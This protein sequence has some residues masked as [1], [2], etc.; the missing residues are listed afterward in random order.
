MPDFQIIQSISDELRRQI[1]T[2]LDTVPGASFGLAGDIDRISLQPPD[3]PMGTDIVASLYLYHIDIDGHLRN[4]PAIPDR[5]AGDLWHQPP[6]PLR[7]HYL[8]T[9][10]GDE[11]ATNQVI[12]ALV[13]QHLHDNP[14]FDTVGEQV[15]DDENGAAPLS[16]RARFA[17]L[18][19]EAKT[20]L[21]SAF[22]TALRLSLTLVVEIVGLAS[23]RAPRSVPRI[24]Q[25]GTTY[26]SKQRERAGG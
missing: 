12:A 25:T 7:L 22:N 20:Q 6:L 26:V 8:L 15:L 18:T 17:P 5:T 3:Q 4:Q 2:T 16:L 11:D 13:I 1:V 19:P 24:G 21:W 9:P 23:G 14:T 10:F